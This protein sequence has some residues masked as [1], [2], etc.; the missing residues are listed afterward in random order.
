MDATPGHYRFMSEGLDAVL[1]STDHA[2]GDTSYII[3]VVD[4]ANIPHD[5]MIAQAQV[6]GLEMQSHYWIVWNVKTQKRA[7]VKAILAS[8]DTDAEKVAK[9]AEV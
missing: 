1:R 2:D 5:R 7:Q 9:L 3:P 6:I 8:D 4:A